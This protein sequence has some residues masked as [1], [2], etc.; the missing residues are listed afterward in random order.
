M[1]LK[2]STIPST[3]M[4]DVMLGRTVLIEVFKQKSEPS[5]CMDDAGRHHLT[6]AATES[7]LRGQ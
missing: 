5:R 3:V 1:P 4:G 7:L 6:D 2:K